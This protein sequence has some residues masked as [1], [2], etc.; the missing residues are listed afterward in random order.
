[1]RLFIR[2]ILT[3]LLIIPMCT[4]FYLTYTNYSGTEITTYLKYF[5]TTL[6]YI[7]ATTVISV[8]LG[9]LGAL[10]I[11][12]FNIPHRGILEKLYI[13]PLLFPSYMMALIYGELDRS[14]MNI[15][16]LIFISVLVSIPYVY[17]IMYSYISSVSQSYMNTADIFKISKF[18]QYRKILL[19]L[20]TP[21]IISSSIIVMSDA[22]SEFGASVF[23]GVN[24]LMVVIYNQWFGI[25]NIG[26]ATFISSTL[27]TLLF[28]GLY[29]KSYIQ[30]KNIINPITSGTNKLIEINK[31]YI[32]TILLYIP[33]V[34][35][36]FVP[37]VVLNE[38][39]VLSYRYTDFTDLIKITFNTLGFAGIVICMT[40]L[41][42]ISLL[43][44]FKNNKV[45]ST[46]QSMNYALPGLLLS[47]VMLNLFTSLNVYI[48]LLLLIYA[49]TIKYN[50]LM[51]NSI[52]GYTSR[53]DRRLYYSTKS[54]G[55]D[56]YWYVK[57]IQ[58]PLATKGI[59]LGSMLIFIDV[60]RELPMMLTL[61]PYNFETLSTKAFY[62]YNSEWVFYTA[63]YFVIMIICSLPVVIYFTRKINDKS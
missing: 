21:G 28:V 12:S 22:I 6:L 15:W 24:T 39:M 42:S 36:L 29:L 58:V 38:W 20:V 32:I 31:S 53:I 55:K 54:I 46:L 56:S 10:F 25:Y 37:L 49:F 1:M 45:I 3:L 34:F 14:F 59:L 8:I 63:P 5:N 41:M 44:L 11:S 47:I 61:R 17:I 50:V 51:T 33:L 43:Y 13:I 2:T 16:G 52:E 18:K 27:V 19:P 26:N 4:L 60:I 7:S 30:H 57:N 40:V 35:S 9:T 62:Y 23:F 48:S